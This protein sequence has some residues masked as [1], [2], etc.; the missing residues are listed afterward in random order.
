M[1][2]LPQEVRRVALSATHGRRFGFANR[3]RAIPADTL[4]VLF[5]HGDVIIGYHRCPGRIVVMDEGAFLPPP[6]RM[7]APLLTMALMI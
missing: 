1:F 4:V 7:I 2:C 5:A 6:W 3:T